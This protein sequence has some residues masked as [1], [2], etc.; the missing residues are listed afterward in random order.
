MAVLH[1]TDRQVQ[2]LELAA[3][4]HADKEIAVALGVSIHTVRT[5]LQRL[6]RAEGFSNRA[7]AVAAWLGQQALETAGP[8]PVLGGA[9]L[10]SEEERV[11]QAAAQV[12]AAQVAVQTILAP[13]QVDLI[14]LE[15][16]A[17][18]LQP[19]EWD[20]TLARTAE[21]SARQMAR[22]GHLGTVIDEI[23]APDGRPLRAENVG[24]WSGINDRQLHA[25][26]TADPRQRANLL[27]AHTSVGAA[28][29]VTDAGVAFLSVIFA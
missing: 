5:H 25:L 20:K 14:N 6:Y 29:A 8:P 2:I 10:A 22:D 11:S 21:T 4:G 13:V 16:T 18:G 15:R 7:E 27:G 17:G 1:C 3:R 28:W 9:E 23:A 19:L 26:F 24:Y 12:A